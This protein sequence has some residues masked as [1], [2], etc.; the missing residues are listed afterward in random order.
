MTVP[1]LHDSVLEQRATIRGMVA[2]AARAISPHYPLETFIARNPVA[3]YE[4]LRFEDAIRAVAADHDAGLTHPEPVF[5]QLFDAGRITEDDLRHAIAFHVAEARSRRILCCGEK[6]VTVGELLL[7]DLCH[8]PEGPSPHPTLRT[9]AALRSPKVHARIDEHVGRWL[10]AAFADASWSRRTEDV[11]LWEAWRRLAPLD[12]RLPRRVRSGIRWSPTHPEDA[13]ADVLGQW[14]WD[15]ATATQY[16]RAHVLAQPGWTAAVRHAAMT[17]NERM[18][19]TALIAL[20]V[21]LE[22]LLLDD[23]DITPEELGYTRRTAD[24]PAPDDDRIDVVGRA[25]GV[26]VTDPAVRQGLSRVL[27]LVDPASRRAIWQEAYERGVARRLAPAIAPVLRPVG[28]SAERPIAQAVFCIDPRSEGIRRHLEAAGRV[29]TLGFAGF[30]AVPIWFRSAAGGP[31]VASCPVLLTPRRAVSESSSDHEPLARWQGR[32]A[33]GHAL[34]GT[35]GRVKDSTIAP[36]ALAETAGWLMGPAMAA[37]TVSPT[38][39][40]ALVEQVG[41]LLPAKPATRLDADVAMNLDERVLYAEAAL[42][43]MGLVDGF[44][45]LVVLAGHGAAVTNN[46]YASALQCG[47]CG[48]HEGAPNARAAAL[49]FNDP[50]TRARLAER[51]IA[52]PD[53]TL[54]VAAQ[55]DTVTDAVRLLEPW[56]IP[57]TH[58]DDV[59]VLEAV[60]DRARAGHAAERLAVLPGAAGADPL[61]ETARRGADWAEVYPEWGLAGNAAFIVG[62]R[63]ITAGHDLGRRAFLHS[64][65]ADADPDGSG[66]ETILTA[67]MIVAQWINAQYAASAL[68]PD[69]FG[70]GPKPLHNVVGTIGVLSGYGGDLRIGLPWQSVGVGGELAHEPVRLQVFV[71]APFARLNLLLES[72]EVVRDLVDKEWITLRAR[73]HDTDRWLRFGPYGWVAEPDLNAVPADTPASTLENLEASR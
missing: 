69:R 73:E 4:R 66:L 39:W 70:A 25:A 26:D 51:G 63:S 49:V 47:A 54:F 6:E 72:A 59:E 38:G 27:S 7:L 62:P 32:L 43:M 60:F 8:A 64:Y 13:I 17:G 2:A 10:S 50:P 14:E 5:R 53:D 68:S 20:R 9:P 65:D 52:I 34:R 36:F 3:D 57:A 23:H 24:P 22:S 15:D 55:H 46:P 21:T 30:F 33:C 31:A 28:P 12:L 29:E 19:V 42:R 58:A 48:G 71:Q 1:S 67:P 44:A 11:G 40:R 56:A 45:R 16:L 37:R 35:F 61:R 41:R 18:S